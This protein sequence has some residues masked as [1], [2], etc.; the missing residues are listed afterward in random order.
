MASVDLYVPLIAQFLVWGIIIQGE[1]IIA[2]FHEASITIKLT[3]KLHT[4]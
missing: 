2:K 3:T 4:R 1:I